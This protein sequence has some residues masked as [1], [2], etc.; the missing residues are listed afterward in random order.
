MNLSLIVCGESLR[1]LACHCGNNTKDLWHNRSGS[2]SKAP[3]G[4]FAHSF[5]RFTLPTVKVAAASFSL[6]H[7][8]SIAK[9]DSGLWGKKVNNCE[10]T[11]KRNPVFRHLF[12]VATFSTRKKVMLLH[13]L[14]AE[15]KKNVCL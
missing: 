12:S 8:T 3:R 14:S 9:K 11:I 7:G 5:R 10:S 2:K 15:K 13:V 4:V 6:L 1:G